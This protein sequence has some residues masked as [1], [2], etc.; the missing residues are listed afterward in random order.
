MICAQGRKLRW[1]WGYP[2]KSIPPVDDAYILFDTEACG[3]AIQIKGLTVVNYSGVLNELAHFTGVFWAFWERNLLI[4]AFPPDA[5]EQLVIIKGLATALSALGHGHTEVSSLEIE[6]A[7]GHPVIPYRPPV[8]YCFI[9]EFQVDKMMCEDNFHGPKDVDDFETGLLTGV[10]GA[11]AV[12]VDSVVKLFHFLHPADILIDRKD[13]LYGVDG[14]SFIWLGKDGVISERSVKEALEK[15]SLATVI[16]KRTQIKIESR[17]FSDPSVIPIETVP[18]L[19]DGI[20][21]RGGLFSRV[22]AYGM[23]KLL[24]W[25]IVTQRSLVL[26]Y[27]IDLPLLAKIEEIMRYHKR[28]IDPEI[29]SRARV[30]IQ[31]KSF[32]DGDNYYF[33]FY[34]KRDAIPFLIAALFKAI[35]E[36]QEQRDE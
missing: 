17:V 26:P 30:A 9:G 23:G 32:G 16:D 3:K 19:G 36:Q 11:L 2:Y 21:F 1:F 14:L 15:L 7:G 4:L 13:N 10:P 12:N 34:Q 33:N 18:D 5:P 35:D 31:T 20:K 6:G 27:L 22:E 24:P 8:Y 28:P 25:E 29:M